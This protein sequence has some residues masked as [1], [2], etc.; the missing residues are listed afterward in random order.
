MLKKIFVLAGTV[1]L[2]WALAVP[3]HAE[4]IWNRGNTADP[5]TLDPQKASTTY[6]AHILRD[7]FEGLV[8]ADAKADLIPGVAESWTISDNG[9]V[10]TFRIRPDAVWSNGDRVTADDFVYGFRRLQD[11]E[12]AAEYASMLYVVKN[13][14][15][16]NTGKLPPEDM[17]VRAV[18]GKTLE[19][20]LNAPTPYFLE[21][22]THQS[23]YPVHRPSVE[24]IGA[25]W[26]RPG[27][28]V[29]N[30]PFTLSERIPNDHI[31]L[32]RN[33][34]FHDAGRV[35]LDGVVFYPTQDRSTAIKRFQAGELDSNDELPVEQL[36]ELRMK[37]GDQVHVGPYLGVYYCF[38]NVKKE[39]WSNPR[40]RRA[41][42]LLIDREFL[43][44][45]VWGGFM[46]PAYGMVSP[47]ISGYRS[48]QA[49]YA[50]MP[51]IDREDEA[52]RILDELGY[53]PGNRLKLELRYDTSENNLNTAVAIQ[54]Q[55]RP[56]GIVVS[57]LN[58]DAKTHFSYLEGG[59]D[60]DYARSGWIG[61]YKDPETFLGTM[62][63]LSGNNL[64]HYESPEF[65]RLMDAAA[66]SGA[67]PEKRMNLLAEAEEEMIENTGIMPLLFFGFQNIV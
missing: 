28:L 65:E 62:R 12:T 6:E 2:A 40:L 55:L 67:D 29:S 9:T 15:A 16:V 54:E 33:P 13:A 25:E 36:T 22:L 53:S 48:Y 66:A 24:R 27:N 34:K 3:I 35:R 43:A 7:L 14:E 47:G 46:I 4:M 32:V 23:T 11:P 1:V 59:G 64:G 26:T 56:F 5:E 17:G 8:M 61:D 63:R 10:Y 51:Q 39:P 38:I 58:T 52:K 18:D 60:F 30:G 57:L 21:M 42:S 31:K 37:F 41:I 49:D 45:K 44:E 19:I 20:S 50:T